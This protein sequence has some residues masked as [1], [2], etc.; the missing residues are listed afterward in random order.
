M[1]AQT[2]G[3]AT[4]ATYQSTSGAK[5]TKLPDPDRLDTGKL[6]GPTYD[7]WER[8]FL[9]KL[10]HNNDHYPTESLQVSYVLARITGQAQQQLEV[11]LSAAERVGLV[12][13]PIITLKDLFQ[14]LRSHFKHPFRNVQATEE[15]DRLVYKPGADMHKFILRYDQLCNESDTDRSK[16]KSILLRKIPVAWQSSLIS[17][18]LDDS[19]SY[20][21]FKQHVQAQDLIQ[22][23]RVS[24][25]DASPGLRLRSRT[26]ITKKPSKEKISLSN[27][28]AKADTSCYK[29]GGTGHFA[30]QCPTADA[31][32]LE[33][34][35]NQASEPEDQSADDLLDQETDDESDDVAEIDDLEI[36]EAETSLKGSL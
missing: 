13:D 7:A 25:R 14:V 11:K 21:E 34:D 36:N 32:A 1:T 6:P 22:G 31:H 17:Y 8:L 16:L 3:N 9:N 5:S 2:P 24:R 28:Q 18:C 35:W 30:R 29:C 10:H 15:L 23:S 26:T 27:P 19:V 12:Q 4:F 20:I 33:K